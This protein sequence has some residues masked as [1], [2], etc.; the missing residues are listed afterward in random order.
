[1]LR[2]NYEKMSLVFL[3]KEL[4][5]VISS[6]FTPPNNSRFLTNLNTSSRSL[7]FHIIAVDTSLALA[8]NL[9]ASTVYSV[10]KGSRRKHDSLHPT[11]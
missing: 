5:F 8:A 6:I 7:A 4:C 1:M 10:L 11:M 3:W 2:H 9:S